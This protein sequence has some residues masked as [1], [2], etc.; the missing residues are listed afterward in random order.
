MLSKLVMPEIEWEQMSHFEV[1]SALIAQVWI[2]SPLFGPTQPSKQMLTSSSQWWAPGL[3]SKLHGTSLLFSLTV[4]PMKMRQNSYQV[5]AFSLQ[6]KSKL[7]SHFIAVMP[8]PICRAFQTVTYIDFP[9]CNSYCATLRNR[10]PNRWWQKWWW[11]IRRAVRFAT[12]EPLLLK[13]K[14]AQ[15]ADLKWV[16]T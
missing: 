6:M 11:R 1:T 8:C 3:F 9:R 7:I 2:S 16:H 12:V 10:I 14:T 5:L 4:S 15:L 13:L